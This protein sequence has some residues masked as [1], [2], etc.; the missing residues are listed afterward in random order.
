[1]SEPAIARVA[2]ATLHGLRARRVRVEVDLSA[3]L[4]AFQLVGLP[5]AGV[6]EARERIGAALR[7]SGL[8]W[9][10]GRITI[11]LAPADL[12]KD[13]AAMDLAIATALLLASGQ[14]PRPDESHLRRALLLGELALD[15]AL[16]PAR[17]AVAF[18]QLAVAALLADVFQGQR[19][20][21][22][23]ARGEALRALFVKRLRDARGDAPRGQ[24]E[25]G[26]AMGVGWPPDVEPVTAPYRLG[27]LDPRTVQQHPPVF[28]GFGS[29]AAR[30]EPARRVQPA[31]QAQC[32]VFD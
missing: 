27:R 22:R 7:H 32:L 30:L 17:A 31:V 12:R 9:P 11:H 15:G 20:G 16:R 18:V 1:M 10:E 14:I 25:H 24:G 23:A 26:D 29:E 28:H 8:Y 5:S 13:G 19:F 2:T 21:E 4:P 6:R 3:D